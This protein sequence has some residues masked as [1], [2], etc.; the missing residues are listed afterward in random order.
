MVQPVPAPF[1]IKVELKIKIKD[2][3][4]SRKL[5]LLS[6]GNCISGAAINIGT[7]QLPNPPKVIGIKK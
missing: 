2:G 3:T 1:S 5:K 6:L 4:K 7:I